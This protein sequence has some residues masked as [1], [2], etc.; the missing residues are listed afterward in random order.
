MTNPDSMLQ[1]SCGIVSVYHVPYHGATTQG[2]KN[3][4]PKLEPKHRG[5]PEGCRNTHELMELLMGE[6]GEAWMGYVIFQTVTNPNNPHQQ[7]FR[8]TLEQLGITISQAAMLAGQR[9]YDLKN[10]H[11]YPGRKSA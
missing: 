6:C 3:M 5:V 10:Q 9:N 2:E 4:K 8:D 1:Y 11:T 7:L